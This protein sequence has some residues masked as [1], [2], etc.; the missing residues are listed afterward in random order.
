MCRS[1]E[2]VLGQAFATF[3]NISDKTE[4]V[5]DNRSKCGIFKTTDIYSNIKIK[6]FLV[7][8]KYSYLCNIMYHRLFNILFIFYKL[9]NV[10]K[11]ILS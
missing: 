1:A 9:C 11:I 5:D 4:N 6:Q 2:S 7:V 8:L 10:K 3:G